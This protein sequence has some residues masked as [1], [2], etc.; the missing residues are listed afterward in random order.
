RQLSLFLVIAV[1]SASCTTFR[2]PGDLQ[3]SDYQDSGADEMPEPSLTWKG[4][5]KVTTPQSEI[6]FDWPVDTARLSQPFRLEKR[7]PH[8]GIDL[9][10]PKNTPILAAENGYVIYTGRGF[11]GYGNLIVIE[12]NSEWATLY[13]HL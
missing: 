7:R 10:G 6:A 4:E 5:R 1:I 9:A 11:R 2:G 3:T 12:H 13:A 8:W